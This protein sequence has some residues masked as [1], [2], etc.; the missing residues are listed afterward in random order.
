MSLQRPSHWLAGRGTCCCGS[1]DVASLL[2]Q[3]VGACSWQ[4]RSKLLCRLLWLSPLAVLHL[5]QMRLATCR[6]PRQPQSRK[7]R[8]A[9][10]VPT[11]QEVRDSVEG[12]AA[13]GSIPGTV[14]NVTKPF[15]QSLWRR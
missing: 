2:E 4:S 5:F 9:P 11:V 1:S 10:G 7:S 8:S 15:L 3:L 14:A 13:G 12:Y 6:S